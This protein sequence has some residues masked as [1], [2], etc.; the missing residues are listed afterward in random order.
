VAHAFNLST[1]GKGRCLCDFEDS[2]VYRESSRTAQ[3]YTERPCIEK[4]KTKKKRRKRRK[5]GG[6]GMSQAW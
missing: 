1:G 5:A 6:G 2:V 4:L 3:G